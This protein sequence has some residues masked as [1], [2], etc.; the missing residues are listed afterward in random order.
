MCIEYRGVILVGH[1]MVRHHVQDGLHHWFQNAKGGH[2]F[3]QDGLETRTYAPLTDT[4]RGNPDPLTLCPPTSPHMVALSHA[5]VSSAH[6]RK[7][8]RTRT[9]THHHS[10]PPPPHTHTFSLHYSTT[11]APCT[12]HPHHVLSGFSQP[13]PL[14]AGGERVG[15]KRMPGSS[16]RY[17]RAWGLWGERGRAW[18]GQY[19]G[20]G[21][22]RG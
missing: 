15:G 16:T 21:G 11:S 12:T 14:W 4:R 8:T 9:H 19:A 1:H 5:H 3:S 22:G 10:T 2:V 7:R 6:T 20:G 18:Q 13:H 17:V